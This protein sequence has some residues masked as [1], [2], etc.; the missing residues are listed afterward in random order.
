MESGIPARLSA[1][2]LRKFGLLVGGVFVALAALLRWRGQVVAPAIAGT[3]GAMLV[4]AGVVVPGRLGP[5][6]RGWMQ[7]AIVLSKVTTPIFLGLVYFVVITPMGLV[8]RRFG[9]NPLVHVAGDVGFWKPR[10]SGERRSA[11]DHQF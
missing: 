6:Y 11:L 4:L 3:L 9:R 1:G 8:R 2:E 5:V 10:P 7:L